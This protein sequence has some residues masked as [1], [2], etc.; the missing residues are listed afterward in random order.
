[1]VKATHAIDL[2]TAADHLDSPGFWH[3]DPVPA[4]YFIR[5]TVLWGSLFWGATILRFAIEAA[6]AA[7]QPTGQPVVA[8]RDSRFLLGRVVLI[9]GIAGF[10]VAFHLHRLAMPGP[11]RVYVA[12][13]VA[14]I[15]LG[16]AIRQWAV[17]TLGRFFTFKLTVQSDQRVVDSGPYRVVRHPSYSGV[18][19]SGFGTAV[20]L[21][22]WVSLVVIVVPSVLAL[23]RRIQVEEGM[24]R[25]GLG[26]D[27]DRYAASRKRLVPGVW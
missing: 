1:V 20:A 5:T 17:H 15:F 19:L 9:T 25:E 2:S 8:D 10:L 11:G 6:N 24:L 27:Y 22:N 7:R 26:P 23:A 3:A 21:G 13:G 14:L 16:I 18:L 4:E 12:V